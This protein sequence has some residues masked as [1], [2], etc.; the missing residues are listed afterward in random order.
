MDRM[1]AAEERI[2]TEKIRQKL[3][4]VNLAA[5]EHFSPVQDHVKFTLQ[6]A[7]FKC[8]YECFDRER[9]YDEIS[10]CVENCSVPVDRSQH[11]LEDEMA[12]FQGA[13]LPWIFFNDDESVE[14]Q[15]ILFFH[16]RKCKCNISL[17]RLN[18]RS[19]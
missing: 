8:A 10:D 19:V 6:Q 15:R 16:K 7:Y 1:A 3:H 17:T 11:M 5:E 4:Q 2:V 9:S 12:N 18:S 14:T 13:L